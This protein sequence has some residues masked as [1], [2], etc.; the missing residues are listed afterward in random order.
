MC[1]KANIPTIPAGDGRTMVTVTGAGDGG[2]V[3]RPDAS[4]V[5]GRGVVGTAVTGKEG[6]A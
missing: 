6:A 5:V 1:W 4:G 3:S 2:E